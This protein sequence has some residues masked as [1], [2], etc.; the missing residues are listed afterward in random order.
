MHNRALGATPMHNNHKEG[1]PMAVEIH[2]IKET[3]HHKAVVDM[4]H[5]GSLIK[6]PRHLFNA[7]S[8]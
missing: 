6:S 8:R 1:T 7:P 4:V 3:Q 2:T 5:L